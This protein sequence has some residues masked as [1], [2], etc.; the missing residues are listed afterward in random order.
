MTVELGLIHPP[1]GT[2]AFVIESVAKDIKIS[3]V[4]LGARPFVLTDFLRLAILIAFPIIATFLP[5]RM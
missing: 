1:V 4:F 2:N 5:P 3:T